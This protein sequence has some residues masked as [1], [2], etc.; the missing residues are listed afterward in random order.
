MQGKRRKKVGKAPMNLAYVQ[1]I[2]KISLETW[3][4]RL[5]WSLMN[6]LVYLQHLSQ[7][8]CTETRQR[9]LY[10]NSVIMVENCVCLQTLT[11]KTELIMAP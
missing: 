5:D 2:R 7:T 10:D 8:F 11:K 1:A 6:S 4:G 9:P 3:E